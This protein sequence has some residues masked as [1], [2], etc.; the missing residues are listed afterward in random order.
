ME[1]RYFPLFVDISEMKIFIAGGGRIA[2]R[3]VKTLLDFSQDITVAAPVLCEE[4]KGFVGAE[5]VRWLSAA[6]TADMLAGADLVLAA[7]DDPNVNREILRDCR[8]LERGERRRIL[9]NVADDKTLCDFYFPSIVQREE[10]VIG[11]NSGGKN[12]GK[13]S[14]TRRKIEGL[15]K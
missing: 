6:Y 13:V 12:P 5:K 11:I 10:I 3:R 8:E 14:R 1:S 2:A 15:L 7:T 4:M 9:V